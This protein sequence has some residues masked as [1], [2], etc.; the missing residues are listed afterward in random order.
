[1]ERIWSPEVEDLYGLT[2]PELQQSRSTSASAV[3]AKGENSSLLWVIS[4]PRS[5]QLNKAY[6]F[7]KI[8]MSIPG[9][10]PPW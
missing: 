2:V 1:M 9:V 10:R 7:I 4:N 6:L 5:L 3:C 8:W